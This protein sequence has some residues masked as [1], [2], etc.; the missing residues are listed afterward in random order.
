MP[1]E[2]KVYTSEGVKKVYVLNGS[3]KGK[4]SVTMKVTEK[5]L[6]GFTKAGMP[7]IEIQDISR[8]NVRHCLGCLH[9]WGQSEGHCVIQNDDVKMV[10]H[11]I[12]ASD[13]V[14]VSFPLYFFSMPG[15]CKLLLDR[16]L[17]MMC[18]Y[19]GQEAPKDGRSFHGLRYYN[20]AQRFVVI[21]SCAYTETSEV[22]KPLRYQLDCIAGKDGYTPIFVPQLLTL[23]EYPNERKRN[24][25]MEKFVTAGEHFRKDGKLPRE[26][27]DLLSKPPFSPLAYKT[28]LDVFWTSE[29]NKGKKPDHKEEKHV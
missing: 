14:I 9:C 6:E 18:T 11:K 15:E 28:L 13:V 1:N 7:E 19:E 4:N 23:T 2:E 8:L 10:K 27:I 20:P 21:S 16:L 29:R 12:I 26:E 22:Y 5:F 3:P 17:S 25:Y 24:R